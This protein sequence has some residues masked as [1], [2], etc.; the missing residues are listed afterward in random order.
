M[1]PDNKVETLVDNYQGGRF[2]RP[3]YWGSDFAS[4]RALLT[5]PYYYH[6]DDQFFLMFPAQGDRS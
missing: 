3:N 4:R 2:N 1:G 6:F 5:L